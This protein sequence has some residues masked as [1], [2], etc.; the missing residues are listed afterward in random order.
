MKTHEEVV[1][2]L[3]EKFQRL[4]A[5]EIRRVYKKAYEKGLEDGQEF[6]RTQ[7]R[8]EI[9]AADPEDLDLED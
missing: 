6:L 5:T 2:K 4:V 7:L 3:V 1:D 8:D 9:L